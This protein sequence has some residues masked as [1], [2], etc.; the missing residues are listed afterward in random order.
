MMKT[1]Y[2]SIY[3]SIYINKTH[4]T[5]FQISTPFLA[6]WVPRSAEE[7]AEFLEKERQAPVEI[8]V[9][10]DSIFGFTGE[11]YQLYKKGL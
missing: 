10:P 2:L 9:N 6:P 11:F 5:W 4:Q 3:L 7:R 1:C 8:S